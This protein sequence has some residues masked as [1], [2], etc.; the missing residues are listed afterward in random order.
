MNQPVSV[1]A[2]FTNK[3]CHKIVAYGSA[4]KKYIFT[5]LTQIQVYLA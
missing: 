1:Q 4:Q 5:M 3:F 2:Q